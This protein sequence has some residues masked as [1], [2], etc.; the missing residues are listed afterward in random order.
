MINK[1]NIV[2]NNR[3]NE[4]LN[5]HPGIPMKL[6]KKAEKSICKISYVYDNKQK[7]GTG[8]FMKFS[9]SL[10]LLITNYHILNQ[11]LMN[12]QIQIEIWIMKK[13]Y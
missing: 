4:V 12:I 6:A 1:N 13:L 8:F 7:F 9:D 3:E 10:K 2:Q 11:N 5:E